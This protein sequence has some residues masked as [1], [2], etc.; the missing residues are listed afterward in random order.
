M[1]N[2]EYC[3]VYDYLEATET[4][5]DDGLEPISLA[6]HGTSD[7]LKEIEKKP[8]NWD[9][10]ISVGLFLDFHSRGALEYISDLHRCVEEFRRK[11][12]VHFVYR[13]APLQKQCDSIIVLE[14]R[15]PCEEFLKNQ[16]EYLKLVNEPFQMYPINLMRNVARTGAKSDF[17]L[18]VDADMVM[19]E[20]FAGKVKKIAN[21]MIDGKKK[22]ALVVRSLPSTPLPNGCRRSLPPTPPTP[23]LSTSEH[24]EL[25]VNDVQNDDEEEEFV[26]RSTRLRSFDLRDGHILDK[27]FQKKPSD[28]DLLSV[29]GIRRGD[30]RRATCPDIFLFDSQNCLMKHVVLRI[31]GSRNCGKKSL[32]NRIHHFATSM[33]PEKVD[34]YGVRM[35]NIVVSADENGNDYSKMTTFLLNGREVT[36]E[37]LLESTLENSPFRQS[38]TMYIVMYN[39][40]SRPSFIYA[41][42]ILERIT[43]ANLNNPV[44]LQLFLIG[45]KCDLKRNQVISTNEAKAVART[46]KCD[47]LEVSALLGMN[48]EETWTTILKELQEPSERRR[49][50]WVERLLN[51]GKGVAKSAEEVFHR[52][53]A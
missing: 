17:H 7:T 30:T 16:K 5:R 33:A 4:F 19:S 42:Q 51:R 46:Y 20:G 39:M 12:T 45:N 37:I 41:T 36:L 40:D 28:K 15:E 14:A 1:H 29:S 52:M 43:L 24:E 23:A 22:N 47:F 31:Y 34:L 53:L 10:P 27:G 50:S 8:F 21:K 35:I 38:K 44:P 6:V 2:N 48:T 26:P 3:I 11:V 18:I 25:F 32:A 13:M 9:G 49:P